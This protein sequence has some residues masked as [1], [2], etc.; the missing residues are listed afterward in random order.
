MSFLIVNLFKLLA[1]LPLKIRAIFG[2]F[3]GSLFYLL[4]TTEKKVAILQLKKALPDQPANYITQ[5]MF[6][7]LGRTIFESL[8]PQQLIQAEAFDVEISNTNLFNSVKDNPQNT[9]CLT[10]HIGSWDLLAAYAISKG[11][12]IAA[13]AKKPNKPYALAILEHLRSS[14]G[15]TIFWRGSGSSKNKLS[16]YI[17]S[18]KVLAAL[19]DQDTRVKNL[20]VPFFNQTAATPVTLVKLAK[21]NQSRIVV[22]FMLRKSEHKFKLFCEEI[23]HTKSSQEILLKYNQI[24]ESCIKTFPEQWVWFH[25]RWRTLQDGNKL[26]T[27]EY[28]KYLNHLSCTNS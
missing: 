22:A 23:D 3:L 17:N 4:P 25:K 21:L 6:Q 18:G 5:K 7:H 10:A 26:S 15:I 14:Y 12:P 1:A 13:F 19:I 28:I 24:L 2:S 20:H 11:I 27:T 8:N 9:I 16:E